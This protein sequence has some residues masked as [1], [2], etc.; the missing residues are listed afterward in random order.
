MAGTAT[1]G[2]L[3]TTALII[4]A[5]AAFSVFFWWRMLGEHAERV[6]NDPAYLRK[7]L[8]RGALYRCNRTG[9][10]DGRPWRSAE[11]DALWFAR[12]LA[13]NLVLFV[14]GSKGQ[15]PAQMNTARHVP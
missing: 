6:Q 4:I 3:K 8:R 12:W 2:A 15:T 9:N 1:G 10:Y 13:I 7:S 5:V 14:F 11:R